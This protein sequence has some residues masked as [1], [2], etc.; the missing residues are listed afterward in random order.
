[1]TRELAD[2]QADAI[3]LVVPAQATR[4]VAKQLAPVIA[5]STP[6]VVCAKGI[7]RGTP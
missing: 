1:M 6:V 3:L 5:D 2:A 7:E 4:A